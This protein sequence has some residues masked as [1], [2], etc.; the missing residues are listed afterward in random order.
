[1]SE[2]LPFDKAKTQAWLEQTRRNIIRL[3]VTHPHET[4]ETYWQHLYFT[5]GMSSRFLYCW[6]ALFIHGIF[7]FW[8]TRTGSSQ[9]EKMHSIMQERVQRPKP[10]TLDLAS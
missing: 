2:L 9:I 3:F 10:P 7:P 4:G 6:L 8:F 5:L 1:M